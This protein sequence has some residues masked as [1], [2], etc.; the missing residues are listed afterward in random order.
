[1]DINFY[2]ANVAATSAKR[3]SKRK[4]SILAHIKI[5]RQ[6]R[7]NGTCHCVVITMSTASSI[8]RT[9]IHASATANAF[10]RIL[11]FLF[12]KMYAASIVHEHNMH[13]FSRQWFP[14]MAG[15]S[16]DGLTGCTSCQQAKKYAE[17]LLLWNDLFNTHAGDMYIGKMR[18]H[19]GVAFV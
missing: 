15:I 18:T 10:Q 1:M 14:E 6:Y 3:G 4:I 8:N 16:G 17:V 9:S 7:T 11:K 12:T 5:W 19:I 13:F 2:R